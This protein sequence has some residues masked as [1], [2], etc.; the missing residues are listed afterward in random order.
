MRPLCPS[1]FHMETAAS[2][3]YRIM[4][5]SS[6]ALLSML[7]IAGCGA[8]Q[9]KT[10]TTP[11]KTIEELQKSIQ[12]ILARDGVPAAGVAMVAKDHVIWATGI[13]KADISVDR[14]A[15]ADTMFR[16]GSISKTFVALA[17]LHLVEQGKLDLEAR[18]RDVAPEIPFRN[19]WESSDP[20][21][22]ADVLEHTAGFDDM[23]PNGAYNLADPP[24][25]P[26]LTVLERASNS[27]VSRW[28]PAER[29]AYSNEDYG[30]A[31]YL[32]EKITGEP[33]DKYVHD[34][35]LVP[36]GMN[37]SGF[38]LSDAIRG[39]IAQGYEGNPPRPV[40]YHNI[41]LSP[42][43]DLKSSPAEMARLVQMFLNRGKVGD[44]QLVKSETIARM[45]T[46]QTTL[47]ARNGLTVGYGIANYTEFV[48]GFQSHGHDGGIDGFISTYRYFPEFGV[49]DVVFLNS[50]S[51]GAALEDI[52]VLLVKYMT[53]SITKPEPAAAQLTSAQLANFVG[54]YECM[55][56]RNELFTFLDRLLNGRRIILENGSLLEM[57]LFGKPQQL[58]PVSANQFRA[59]NASATDRIFARDGTGDLVYAT[60]GFYGRRMSSVWPVIRLGLVALA[61]VLMATSG[62]FALVWIPRKL[63]GRMRNVPSLSIRWLPLAAMGALAGALFVFNAIPGWLAGTRN[64]YTISFCILTWLFAALSVL[65]LILC[66]RTIKNSDVKPIVRVHC[67]LVAFACCGIAGWL[68]WFGM[69]GLRLWR[70]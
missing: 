53:Q 19:P 55:N 28:A 61:F 21:R 59:K 34:T 10:Q 52:D 66:L 68:G 47:A 33:Y 46:P 36:L 40:P 12:A 26:L 2:S 45:E 23:H 13:G 20:V 60:E 51:S 44:T 38:Q 39:E 64:V 11:P 30:I 31:G 29:M 63:L 48:A 35:I 14:N 65:S 1:Y 22:V 69:I 37:L 15:T 6:V 70:Y 17:L 54:Y 27:L 5:V 4:R 3:S 24:D 18:L 9:S 16:V 32:I 62:A 43:G 58:I 67:L 25:I 41:Y 42:A 8:P 49:G 50:S 56:P 57:S 7:P